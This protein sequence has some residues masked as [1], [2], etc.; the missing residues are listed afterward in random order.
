LLRQSPKGNG[1]LKRPGSAKKLPLKLQSTSPSKLP[2]MPSTADVLIRGF[3][4][5]QREAK[6][7]LPPM[8]RTS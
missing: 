4:R 3:S 5:L 7:E 1:T 2:R 6:G 8:A